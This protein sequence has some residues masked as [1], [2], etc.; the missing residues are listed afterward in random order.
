MKNKEN[1]T[2]TPVGWCSLFA[3]IT[4][5]LALWHVPG[6]NIAFA[7]SMVLLIGFLIS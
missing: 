6:M 3:I 2:L 4:G 7:I 1:I 5:V